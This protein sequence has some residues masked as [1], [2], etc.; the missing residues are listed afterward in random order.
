M[1]SDE[2]NE[3]GRMQTDE[4]EGNSPLHTQNVWKLFFFLPSQGGSRLDAVR[5]TENGKWRANFPSSDEDHVSR[6]GS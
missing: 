5:E 4:K 3:E 1:T 6:P 2:N